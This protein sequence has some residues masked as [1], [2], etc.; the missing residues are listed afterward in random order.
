MDG[1]HENV[2]N[3]RLAEVIIYGLGINNAH[4][5]A[6]LGLHQSRSLGTDPAGQTL[7]KHSGHLDMHR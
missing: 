2:T 3:L 5:M 4:V 1:F 7:V 6:S